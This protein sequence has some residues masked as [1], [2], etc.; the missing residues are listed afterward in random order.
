[1]H[2]SRLILG[3]LAAGAAFIAPMALLSANVDPGAL[4]WTLVVLLTMAF[5]V[6]AVWF[7]RNLCTALQRWRR[8]KAGDCCLGCGYPVYGLP[9]ERCPECGQPLARSSYMSARP[10]D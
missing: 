5:L 9:S 10:P 6:A 4:G 8:V 1:M 3:F 2:R 7:I